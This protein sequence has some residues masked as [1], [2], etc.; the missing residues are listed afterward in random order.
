M[1]DYYT[2]EEYYAK[3][4][5]AIKQS[6][7]EAQ[8]QR[9]EDFKNRMLK[10]REEEAAG[11]IK[12]L[13][14]IEEQEE[15]ILTLEDKKKFEALQNQY[16][17]TTPVVKSGLS[18][19]SLPPPPPDV[20]TTET[21]QEQI[22][23]AAYEETIKTETS[24]N[25]NPVQLNDTQQKISALKK[26]VSILIKQIR[27]L[28]ARK[29]RTKN[30]KDLLGI[31]KLIKSYT[32]DISVIEKLLDGLAATENI[33]VNTVP[34]PGF[35]YMPDGTL[36]S[37]AEHKALNRT[38]GCAPNNLKVLGVSEAEDKII[39]NIEFDTSDINQ[40]GETRDFFVY[41]TY[42]SAFTLEITDS[43]N[44][45]Y[46]FFTNAFQTAHANIKNQIIA[47]SYEFSVT[48]PSISDASAKQY[49]IHIIAVGNTTHS[50]HERVDFED[51]SIDLN[52]SIGSKS[53]LLRKVLY[54]TA[55]KT[56]DYA[57]SAT[58][59]NTGKEESTHLQNPSAT[60][61]ATFVDS[62]KAAM[63][64]T[65]A[66]EVSYTARDGRAFQISRQP[67]DLDIFVKVERTVG[68]AAV[69]IEGEDTSSSTYYRWPLNNIDGLAEGMELAKN[70]SD[71]TLNSSIK[72]YEQ[73]ITTGVNTRCAKNVVAKRVEALDTVSASPTFTRDITAK[74]VLVKTQTGNV[75][76][77]KQQ[78][79]AF[80]DNTATFLAYGPEDIEK[81]TGWRIEFN[82]LKA[83][84]ATVTTT[85]TSAVSSSTSIPVASGDGIVDNVSVMSGIGVNAAAGNPTVTAIGSYSGSTATLTVGSAQTLEDGITL[86]F[87]GA[88]TV[89]TISGNVVFRKEGKTYGSGYEMPGWDGKFYFNLENFI[90]AT[91]ET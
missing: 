49:D 54:Q 17:T 9:Q 81:L 82:N 5:A 48:F 70:S 13:I 16:T 29:K 14:D 41:G 36:M 40:D 66:F 24:F 65:S 2:S 84:L 35:H 55:S 44:K 88:G 11:D 67:V 50:V 46:N 68:S 39:Q 76:F 45:Y 53:V 31:D 91:N 64:K 71:V 60:S 74:G 87:A 75:V 69:P 86:T 22:I 6:A 23:E 27:D 77:D 90:T 18:E 38:A 8:K 58:T 25:Y 63:G 4:D 85:T 12:G 32:V 28:E 34:P 43:D 80:K 51:G 42:G 3:K 15:Y 83:E 61:D 20:S 62:A 10:D 47:G 19:S 1:A 72:Y 57:L 89:L 7:L 56:L 33:I 52:S 30:D 78:A 59:P 21:E 73:V 26:E 37:D 79:D